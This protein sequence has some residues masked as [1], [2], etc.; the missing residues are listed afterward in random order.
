MHNKSEQSMISPKPLLLVC[1]PESH[2]ER[3]NATELTLPAAFAHPDAAVS[4]SAQ[5]KGWLRKLAGNHRVFSAND[6]ESLVLRLNTY[7]LLIVSPLSLNTLAKFALGLRDSFPAE[8]LWQFSALGKPILLDE[9]CLPNEH[10]SMNPHLVKIYRRHWQTLISGTIS[11]FSH[12][13]LS[14]KAT[15]M[16]RAKA[17]ANRQLP[18]SARVFITRDDIIAAAE[19]LE[20]FKI[21]HSAI[22]TDLAR[23]E[24]QARGVVIIQD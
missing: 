23:E 24:A 6:C 4:F 2:P 16:I 9:T 10:T 21:P 22:I 1:Q 19:S 18:V 11:G 20:P 7:D 5:Q 14:E 12:E 3:Q 8:L 17:A 15:R 13:N